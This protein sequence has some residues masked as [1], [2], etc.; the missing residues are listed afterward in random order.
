MS[1]LPEETG[2]ERV[3]AIVAGLGRLG[4]LPVSEHVQVFDEAF[5]GL[6][7]TLAT[8]VEEQ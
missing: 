1:E 3:D 6:E 5:S 8:A 7:S 2:D 4:E